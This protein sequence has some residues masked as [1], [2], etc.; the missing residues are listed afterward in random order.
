MQGGKRLVAYIIPKQESPPRTDDLRTFLKSKLPDYMVPSAFVLLD[1]LPLMPNGKVDRNDLP[2]PDQ[3]RAV[4]DAGYVAPRTLVEELLAEIWA[5]VLK[6]DKVGI[7]DNFFDLG[8]HSLL[9]TQLVSRIRESLQVEFPLRALFEKP[10]VGGLAE[11]VEEARRKEHGLQARPMLRVS[12]ERPMP[13]SFAQ[14]RLW[15]LDLLQ[16]NSFTYNLPSRRRFKGTLDVTVLQRSLEEIVRRHEALRTIFKTIDGTPFQ[17]VRQESI[18]PLPVVDLSDRSGSEREDQVRRLVADEARN[19]FD[20]TRGPLLRAKLLRLGREDHILLVTMHHIVSDGWSMEV[21]FRELSVLYEAFSKDRPSPLP[22]LPVQYPDYA[23]WQRDWLQGEIL[24]SQ[25]SYWRNQLRNVPTLELPMDRPRPPVQSFAGASES[26]VIDKDLSAALKSLCRR[27]R[28]TLFMMLVAGFQA[29]LH[30]YTGEEDVV[31]GCPIAGRIRPEVEGLIGFFLNTLVL[32]TDFSGDPSFSELLARVRDT[33]LAAYAN[34]DVP[35]EKLLEELRPERDLSRSPLFQVF[36]NMINVREQRIDWHGLNVEAVPGDGLGSKFDLTVYAEESDGE[37]QLRLVYSRDLFNHSRIKELLQQ[38][39]Q[40]LS[41]VVE[42]PERRISSYSLLTPTGTKLLPDP[43]EKL[44]PDWMG[45]VHDRFARQAESSPEHPAITDPCGTWSYG[46][47]NERSNQLSHYLL[48]RGIQREEVVAIYG[49]RSVAI[50]LAMLGV[51][52]AGAAFL[53]LDP[54]Y[55]AA[56]LSEYVKAARPRGLIRLEPAGPLPEELEQSLNAAVR[57]RIILP[58]QKSAWT[59]D[60]LKGY[61]TENPAVPVGP[62]DLACISFTSGSTGG[63]KGILGRHGPLSHFLPW[64]ADKFSL[65]SSDRF[66]MLSGL[67]HDPLQRE[68]FTPL[69]IGASIHVPDP[70]DIGDSGR[71][72]RWM[73]REQITF[74]HLTPAIGRLLIQGIEPDYRLTSLRHGFFVGDKLT[75]ADV[76]SLRRIAPAV[77][78]VN[79]YGSTETQRAVSYYEVP[80]T[81]RD[82]SQKTVLPVGRGMPDVQLLVLN[83]KGGLA[84]VSE[85]GEIHMRS[86]HLARGYLG[87][88]NLTQARF[89]VNPFAGDRADRLY[90]T[91]DLGRYLPDGNAEILGRNDGQIKLRGFRIEP[92]E[93]ETA[94]TR[95]TNVREAVVTVYDNAGERELAGYVVIQPGAAPSVDELRAFLKI[96]L[97]DYMVPSVF[98][99]LNSLPLNPNGK[100]EYRA[101]PDPQSRGARGHAEYVAARDDAERRLCRVWSEVLGVGRVGLDDN[102]FAIGGHSLLAAKLFARLDETFGRSLPLNVLFRAP[103]VRLLAEHY[104]AGSAPET[105]SVIVALTEG[106]TLPAIFGAPGVFGDVI[107]FADLARELGSDQPFYG[108]QAVG[109]DGGEAPLDSIEQMAA[110]YLDEIRKI[111]PHGPYALLGACFGATVAYETARQLLE[112]GEKVTFLGLLD[113]TRREGYETNE[114][115]PPMPRPLKRAKAFGSFFIERLRLYRREMQGLGIAARIRFVMQKIRSL[116]FTVGDRKAFTRVQREIYQHGVVRANIR[117]LDRYHRKPLN[118]GLRAVEIFETSNPRNVTAWSFDWKNLWDGRPV[119]HRVQGKDSGT[120][121]TGENGR[122]LALLLR[123]RL[124]AAF[125]ENAGDSANQQ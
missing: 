99:F 15:F 52:K 19:P 22:E 122:S 85:A 32:R 2:A 84:G 73:M 69:W 33:A 34:Q 106:G 124:K 4:S 87:D 86:P 97:P 16:P 50:A 66:S 35:F 110:L 7:Y 91:G 24:E 44:S 56:R 68:I 105:H 115:P 59:E 103:T 107:C 119:Q 61:A 55:P 47:L 98:V 102:F 113:P 75:W 62:D 96:S 108:L 54:G 116:S 30:R 48:A 92:A 39:K 14:Q 117:A 78:C 94:L 23:A 74:A 88:E 63:P 95:H 27:Q 104:R 57:C 112:A 79:Y 82:G 8:G 71:L 125:A 100:V 20:L 53:I 51:L 81:P 123:D 93:I 11:R 70:D 38:Y 45:A 67:S 18:L 49:H 17:V 31:V 77:Q 43:V 5:G 109:L 10:T 121:L 46:E 25:L 12:R 36:F 9:A 40:L 37:V 58:R 89:V 111:Q 28:V 6:L 60:P 114:N 72:S 42:E 26:L 1:K 29:L 65:T 83:K 118:G 21:F 120:M 64:Q 41:H 13:L 3:N 80:S 76:D 90:K 101:L